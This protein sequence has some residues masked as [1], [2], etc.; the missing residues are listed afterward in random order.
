[1]ANK[2]LQKES[3]Q[4]LTLK[5]MKFKITQIPFHSSQNGFPEAGCVYVC[6]CVGAGG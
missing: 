5:E 1:M 6:V 4:H 3:G 2:L